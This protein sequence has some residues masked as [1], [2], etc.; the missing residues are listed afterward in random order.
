MRH[1]SLRLPS[2]FDK[3]RAS[4]FT[5][6]CASVVDGCWSSEAGRGRELLLKQLESMAQA[7]EFRGILDH[8]WEP[9]DISLFMNRWCNVRISTATEELGN[10]RRFT[11]VRCIGALTTA[12]KVVIG[13]AV[14]WL[15]IALLS[16]NLPALYVGVIAMAAIG[17]RLWTALRQAC[18]GAAA[19]ADRAAAA[20][21]LRRYSVVRRKRRHSRRRRAPQLSDADDRGILDRIDEL[22]ADAA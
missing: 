20:A 8:A 2:R 17:L 21:G 4:R 22:G 11:R 14:I 19:L 10:S 12:A 9:W 7:A 13:A 16:R 5:R 15:A 3:V 18:V 1:K 6:N